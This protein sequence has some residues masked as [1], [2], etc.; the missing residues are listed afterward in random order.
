MLSMANNSP[1]P[2]SRKCQIVTILN[3]VISG[4]VIIVLTML[5]ADDIAYV[6]FGGL[7][8]AG[9]GLQGLRRPQLA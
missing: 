8:G 7:A 2:Q 1:R 4:A 5:Q 3:L 9:V 6:V